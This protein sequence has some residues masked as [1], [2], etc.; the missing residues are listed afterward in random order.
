MSRPS[1]VDFWPDPRVS[2][3]RKRRWLRGLGVTLAG[4]AGVLALTAL[5]AA[6]GG[7]W[8]LVILEGIR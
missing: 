6:L 5:C 8:L 2:R 1:W 3:V 4:V 7:I